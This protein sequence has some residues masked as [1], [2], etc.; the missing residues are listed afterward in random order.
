MIKNGI[1]SFLGFLSHNNLVF[2]SEISTH[3][4]FLSILTLVF[5]S[6][7]PISIPLI[8]N[9]S[10]TYAC[11]SLREKCPHS[12]FFWSIFSRIRT[13]YGKI[14]AVSFR[15]QSE[16][17]N[18]RTRK[19]SNTDTFHAVPF[20]RIFCTFHFLFLQLPQIVGCFLVNGPQVRLAFHGLSGRSQ[21]NIEVH[22]S[23][24]V[25]MFHYCFFNWFVAAAIFS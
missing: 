15:I 18:I 23:F 4:Y 13:E 5:C 8:P 7:H 20:I 14:L 16:S 19:T 25:L 3:S 1:K 22:F 17:G 21:H 6:M 10:S 9:L 24:N 2:L 12:E 11:T